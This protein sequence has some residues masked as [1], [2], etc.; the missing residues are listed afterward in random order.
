M[1]LY[2]IF[3]QTF[4][5]SDPT[6]K[7]LLRGRIYN[8]AVP[9]ISQKTNSSIQRYVFKESGRVSAPLQD[10][11]PFYQMLSNAYNLQSP[12]LWDDN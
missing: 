7:I 11:D 10:S 9:I 3:K 5:H 1:A 2:N 6:G 8:L 4:C 12:G